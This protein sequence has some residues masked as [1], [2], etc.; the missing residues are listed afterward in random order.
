MTESADSQ[1]VQAFMAAFQKL[2]RLVDDMPELIVTEARGNMS[3]RT[4]CN[5]VFDAECEL[6]NKERSRRELYASPTNPAFAKAWREYDAGY[7]APVYEVVE[8]NLPQ[9]EEFFCAEAPL[10]ARSL[11]IDPAALAE[12]ASSDPPEPEPAS[13]DKVREPSKREAREN[14]PTRW[15]QIDDSARSTAAD[16]QFV[17][18][19]MEGYV[20]DLLAHD[21]N[22]KFDAK[23]GIAAWKSLVNEVGFDLAGVFRRRNL[24]P[25]VMI[26]RHVSGNYDASDPLSL[27]AR[28]QQAQEAF[29]YGVQLGALAIMRSI[30]E[31]ILRKHYQLGDGRLGKLIETAAANGLF[32]NEIRLSQIQTLLKLGNDSVHPNSEEL[33]KVFDIEM[34][35]LSLLSVLR[36]LIERTPNNASC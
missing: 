35:V 28:L 33:H 2:R 7:S 12:L 9:L 32:P 10:S 14:A 25:F 1:E 5:A 20:D 3:L 21:R 4:L 34:E 17:M 19:L 36:T 24:T 6:R 18:D 31:I 30:L 29:V 26:P 23:N 11:V 15:E 16:I 27:M 8:P 22:L 13:G